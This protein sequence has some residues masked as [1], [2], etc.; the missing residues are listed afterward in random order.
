M[1]FHRGS[2]LL[3]IVLVPRNQAKDGRVGY[4]AKDTHVLNDIHC[5]ARTQSGA[6]E[7]RAIEPFIPERLGD[8]SCGSL[9]G[10]LSRKSELMFV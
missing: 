3:T 1:A 6:Q 2:E 4:R 8:G 9:A 7:R 5:P 10:V